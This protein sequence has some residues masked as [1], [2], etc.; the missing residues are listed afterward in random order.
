[1]TK[2]VEDIETNE[3]ISLHATVSKEVL[4]DIDKGDY[5]TVVSGVEI[6]KNKNH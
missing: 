5:I 6:I 4:Q 1:M 2:A 3:A